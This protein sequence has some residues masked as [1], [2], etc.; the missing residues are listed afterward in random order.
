LLSFKNKV[1][2]DLEI[3]E[4]IYR[5]Y[6]NVF[7]KFDKENPS[8]DAKIYVP[9]D[10]SRIADH[11]GVDRDIIFGRLYYHLEQKY[12]YSSD[13]VKVHFFANR[14]KEDTKCINFPYMAS[15]LSDLQDQQR[16]YG[17]SLKLSII[18]IAISAVSV[19]FTVYKTLDPAPEAQ[20]NAVQKE[21]KM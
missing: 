9:I 16:K 5:H 7:V 11:F 17:W 6:Y 14:L 18:A 19:G 3:L 20:T 13:G 15:I 10:C 8:R 4:Y 2:T 12:A 21:K 1:P